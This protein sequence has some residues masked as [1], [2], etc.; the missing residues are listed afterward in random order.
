M[1]GLRICDPRL[2][3]VNALP[4][5]GDTV[6]LVGMRPQMVRQP[7]FGLEE[8]AMNTL[9]MTPGGG[10]QNKLLWI[11]IAALGAVAFGIIAL[12]RGETVNAAWLVIASVCIYFIAYRFYALFIAN[13]VLGVERSAADA[14]VSPQ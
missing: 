14:G 4:F 12:H 5:P 3:W 10:I 13:K 6:Q 7:R 11:A 1:A 2:M 9:A 8:M